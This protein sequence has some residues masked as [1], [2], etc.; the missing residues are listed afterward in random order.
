MKFWV[1]SE[2]SRKCLREGYSLPEIHFLS[3]LIFASPWANVQWKW[4]AIQPEISLQQY[5][6][7]MILKAYKENISSAWS[8]LI[9]KCLAHIQVFFSS[10]LVL[11]SCST[12]ALVVQWTHLVFIRRELLPAAERFVVLVSA[13]QCSPSCIHSPE[14]WTFSSLL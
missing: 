10:K 4:S 5:W 2:D 3:V 7:Q 13:L 11:Q 14:Q 12:I 1:F 8:H 9:R 6:L